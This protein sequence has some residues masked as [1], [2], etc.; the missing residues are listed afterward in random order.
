[1]TTEIATLP[2]PQRAA[3]ALES[4]K[5][6]EALKS[7]IIGT[8]GI[9]QINSKDG[10]TEC[11]AAYMRLK[12][13]RVEVEKVGKNAR[14]DATAF[15][16]AVIA[17][18]KRLIQIVAD[19]EERLRKLRDDFDAIEKAAKE[20]REK[21]ERER[22]AAIAARIKAFGRKDIEVTGK[23]SAE[24]ETALSDVQAIEIDDSF[25][26]FFGEAKEARGEAIAMLTDMLARK[27][28]EEDE[29]KRLADERKKFEAERA[30]QEEIDKAAAAERA[31]VAAIEA[32]AQAKAKAEIETQQAEL[33]RKQAE[34]QRAEKERQ[35]AANTATQQQAAQ[36]A[37]AP[38]LQQV[39]VTQPVIP[40]Q[41]QVA[42]S[43]APRRAPTLKLGEIN[44]RLCF[45]V[46]ADF[47]R[48][49]GFAPHAENTTK[50]YHE[51][52][53]R[54]MCQAIIRHVENVSNL[55]H[56]GQDN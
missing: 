22:V 34:I 51:E 56:N 31:R 37:P 29:A 10:R 17:E 39:K 50:M 2:A 4:S 48:S 52:D 8:Q 5:T 28:G 23:T 32:E 25:A 47:L 44:D 54:R 35:E 15:S 40:A 7:L 24:I 46:T 9:T 26:E 18:E 19:E 3:I 36:P 21:A 27:K 20:A 53:F 14:D 42:A 11:H 41:V 33:A 1:M 6:E 45:T 16:K 38:A 55:T 12:N 30:A 49:L 43:N 13:A